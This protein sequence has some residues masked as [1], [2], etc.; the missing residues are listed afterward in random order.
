MDHQFQEKS[1]FALLDVNN[2]YT[3]LPTWKKWLGSIRLESLV[4]ADLVLL[5]EEPPGYSGGILDDVHQQFSRDLRLLFYM[6]HLRVGIEISEDDGADL[7][8]GSS[9][10]RIDG[11][12][13][14][15]TVFRKLFGTPP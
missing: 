3:D 5:V 12:A 11:S 4:H 14:F 6:V 8:C 1:K 10:G 13:V 2:V 9:V 7:L 15:P